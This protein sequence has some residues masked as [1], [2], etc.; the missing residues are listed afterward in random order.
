MTQEGPATGTAN[1]TPELDLD[2]STGKVDAAHQR[3][4]T[5]VIL[6]GL[7]Q[8]SN[9][10]GLHNASGLQG[11][12]PPHTMLDAQISTS[13]HSRQGS[14]DE[15]SCKSWISSRASTNSTSSFGID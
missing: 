2:T 10:S 9:T 13:T 5:Y 14:N 7:G 11:I 4:E 6:A 1:E 12:A 3:A 8:L 15:A